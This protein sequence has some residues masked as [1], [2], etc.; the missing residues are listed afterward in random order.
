MWLTVNTKNISYVMKREKVDTVRKFEGHFPQLK[1]KFSEFVQK[2]F[3]MQIRKQLSSNVSH[4]NS[5]LDASLSL[6][7]SLSLPRVCSL[8]IHNPVN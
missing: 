2:L 6:S 7:L 3:V 5:F 1:G 4:S 8:V